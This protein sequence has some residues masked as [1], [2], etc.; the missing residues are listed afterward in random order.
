MP[1]GLVCCGYVYAKTGKVGYTI[2]FHMIFNFLG[3]AIAVELTKGAA[4]PLKTP[5]SSREWGGCCH[6]IL[7]LS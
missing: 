3:G 4:G 1:L 7:G 5:G 2:A 6:W